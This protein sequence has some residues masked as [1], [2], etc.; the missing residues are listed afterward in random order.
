[1]AI[2]SELSLV[3]WDYFNEDDILG[4]RFGVGDNLGIGGFF[5]ISKAE[6]LEYFNSKI[7]TKKIKE[8]LKKL[9][10]LEIDAYDDYD[11]EAV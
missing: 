9:I 6:I 7:I 4:E 8:E 11:D 3:D 2:V 5:F 1:M 10:E